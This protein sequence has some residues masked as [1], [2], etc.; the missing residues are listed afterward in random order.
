MKPGAKPVAKQRPVPIH[1]QGPY[2]HAGPVEGEDRRVFEGW[3]IAEHAR[4]WVHN[5]VLTKK[6]WDEKA[7]R[8]NIDTMTMEKAVEVTHFPI[9][10][11][12][13][14]RHKFLGSERF[15]AIDLNHAFH[16]LRLDDESKDLFKFTTPFGLVIGAH[17][18]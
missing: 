10:T 5:V 14:L 15:T 2:P 12:E 8:L 18:A 6:K 11:A 1:M 4:G 9:P 7:V 16:Q 17:T 3:N 13:Q